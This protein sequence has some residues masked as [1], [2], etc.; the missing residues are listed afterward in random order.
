MSDQPTPIPKPSSQAVS[1]QKAL[2]V[3]E[4]GNIEREH[5]L[6][7]WSSNYAFLLSLRHEDVEVTAVYKPQKGERPLWDFPDG[8]LCYREYATFLTSQELGWQIVPPTA[9][10]E[11][12]RGIGTMQFFI[13]HDPEINYFTFDEAMHDQLMRIAVFDSIVNNADRK[14]G[15]CLLDARGHVWGIDH[16]I[17][18]N[19]AHKLRTV[20]WDFAGQTIAERLLLDVQRLC[21]SL[22][23]S[24]GDYRQKLQKL[25]SQTEIDAFQRRIDRLLELRKYPLPGPGPNYPWPPV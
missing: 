19:S 14:G 9:L 4:K 10:R 24:K 23:D 12:A 21:L 11:G 18:F 2:E 25:L 20:I 5:G 6:L 7:R 1:I 3:I 13:D 15:H 22:G 8:T 17:T 16:G